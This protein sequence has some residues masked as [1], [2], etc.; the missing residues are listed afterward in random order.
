M[1]RFSL[2]LMTFALLHVV[3][4]PAWAQT[5]TFTISPTSGAN[6]TTITYTGTGYTPGGNVSVLLTG[7]GLVVDDTTADASGAI[8]GTFTAPAR[9]QLTGESTNTIPVFALDQASGTESPRVTFTYVQVAPLPPTGSADTALSTML[10]VVVLL[11][12]GGAALRRLAA[13]P[14][15]L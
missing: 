12:M 9:D 2:L 3:V 15:S 10:L 14:H 6:G 4:F 11:F 5:P 1:K 7:D 13:K 8:R